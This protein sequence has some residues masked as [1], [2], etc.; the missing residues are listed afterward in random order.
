MMKRPIGLGLL[1][2]FSC[3]TPAQADD[4]KAFDGTWSIMLSCGNTDGALGY[5]FVFPSTVKDGDFEGH[6]GEEGKPGWLQIKG[7]IAA[8]GTAKFYADGLVG[9][10]QAAV[11]HR[12]V[13]TEYGYHIAAKFSGD[14]GSGKRV[15]G[16]PCGFTFTRK[17]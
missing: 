13:G 12:P 17:R 2:M 16:R 15:E 7:K 1:L 4:A 9:A 10:S 5:S 14:E 3:F 8:D 11:G 6:K